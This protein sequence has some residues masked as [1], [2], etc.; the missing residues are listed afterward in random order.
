[1]TALNTTGAAPSRHMPALAEHMGTCLRGATT[2]GLTEAVDRFRALH[3]AAGNGSITAQQFAAVIVEEI[4]A[5]ADDPVGWITLMLHAAFRD[6]DT[7]IAL[8]RQAEG[9]V[10]TCADDPANPGNPAEVLLK[11]MALFL[12]APKRVASPA[13]ARV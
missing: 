3:L 6:F 1:M 7:A 10:E 11:E 12:S 5:E 2:M 9:Y 4:R 13:A 8:L